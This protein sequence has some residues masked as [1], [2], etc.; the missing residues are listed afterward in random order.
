MRERDH[1]TKGSNQVVHTAIPNV[2]PY[3]LKI[4]NTPFQ[5]YKSGFCRLCLFPL[6]LMVGVL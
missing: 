2:E 3:T 5:C 4:N 1:A 6:L